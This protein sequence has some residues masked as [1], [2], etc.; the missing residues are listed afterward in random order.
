MA[1][2]D[3]F[4]DECCT[5]INATQGYC[6]ILF[7]S[8]R[9]LKLTATALSRRLKNKLFIQGEHQRSE[10]IEKYL[11]TPNPVLLG[12]SS[13]WEGV[14]VKGDKL[15]LV[16]I[17]KLPF[18]SPGDPVYKRRLQRVAENGGNA[19][20]EIQIPEATISLRQGVGRLIRDINDRGIVMIADKRLQSKPYAREILDSL[21]PMERALSLEQVL[22]FAVKL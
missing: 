1:Y 7:T 11:K 14:D 10:L 5:L 2:A 13:F 16:I 15:K 17:D 18:K 4:A 8:Y 20:K 9:M 3:A 22:E 6:F 19:F 12:T 21:P